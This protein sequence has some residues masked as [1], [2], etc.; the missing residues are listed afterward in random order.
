MLEFTA[1]FS[2]KFGWSIFIPV[3]WFSG[4]WAM[5]C[6]SRPRGG[7]VMPRVYIPAGCCGCLRS[8]PEPA[9]RYFGSIV[10]VWQDKNLHKGDIKKFYITFAITYIC[11]LWHKHQNIKHS[12][13]STDSLKRTACDGY[14]RRKIRLIEC[15]AKC[16]YLKRLTCPI[17]YEPILLPLTQ[18]SVF[19]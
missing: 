7:H 6:H 12:F 3:R 10:V 16:Q 4:S 15:N 14:N 2:L 18:C 19:V 17:F 11:N 8:L 5:P 1:V 9:G 13:L